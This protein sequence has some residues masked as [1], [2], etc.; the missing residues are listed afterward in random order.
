MRDTITL[1]Y[2]L[3]KSI[4]LSSAKSAYASSISTVNLE[5][6]DN[7]IEFVAEVDN[8]IAGYFL[9]TRV[10]DVVTERKYFLVDY[11]CV[12]DDYKR[13]GIAYE[14][15]EYAYNFAKED[16]ASYLELHSNVKR[17][18]AHKLYEKCNYEK[19]D[20]YLYRRGIV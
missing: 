1:L 2:S 19:L 20:S 14:M 15:M 4:Q 13:M 7:Y 12:K 16:G 18:A 11:V 3:T 6:D 9:L 5:F 8:K 17:E 10:Y